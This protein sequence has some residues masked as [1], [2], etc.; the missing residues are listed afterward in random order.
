WISA[1]AIFVAAVL[2]FGIRPFHGGEDW[3]G[4]MRVVRSFA[5]NS[6]MPVLMAS[7]FVEATDP[8]ALDDPK[9]REVL[10]A[11]LTMYPPAGRI[12]PLPFRL[13]RQSIAYLERVLPAALENQTRFLFVCRL[14]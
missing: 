5:G 1:A 10:F 7:G 14:H 8:S 11:P 4:A 3:A 2:S 13:N 6:D 12:V 9:I